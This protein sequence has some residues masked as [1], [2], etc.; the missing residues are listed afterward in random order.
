M[1]CAARARIA[2]SGDRQRQP[3]GVRV[4]GKKDRD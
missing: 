1:I 2:R 3:I 4:V